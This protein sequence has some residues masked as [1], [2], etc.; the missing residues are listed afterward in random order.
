MRYVLA[1]AIRRQRGALE[2]RRRLRKLE[3]LRR[4]RLGYLRAIVVLPRA[5]RHD[6]TATAS[7]RIS[8][9]HVEAVSARAAASRWQH[10]SR[11]A[12]ALSTSPTTCLENLFRR[13][14]QLRRPAAGWCPV[15]RSFVRWPT[16]GPQPLTLFKPARFIIE[17]RH[18]HD[19]DCLTAPPPRPPPPP[20][21]L[22]VR[23]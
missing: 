13:R 1:M 21:I 23:V 7:G 9:P 4:R 15:G 19:F 22:Y 20:V 14:S 16:P 11:R 3:F 5:R 6:S 10:Q 2:W 18:T 17:R 8:I 12:P